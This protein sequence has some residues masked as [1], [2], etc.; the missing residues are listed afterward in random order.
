MSN[1]CRCWWKERHHVQK[2]LQ[3][4]SYRRRQKHGHV[5]VKPLLTCVQLVPLLVERKTPPSVPAKRF[6]PQTAR[7]N[8]S[9]FVKPVFTYFQLAPLLVERKLRRPKSRQRDSCRRR[10]G[11]NSS[12]RQAVIDLCPACAIVG[13]TKT[14]PQYR[15][16]DSCRRVTLYPL[17][18]DGKSRN[19]CVRQAGVS[20]CP[21]CAVVG[22][23]KTRP[24]PVTAKRLVSETAREVTRVSVKPV[25]TVSSLCRCWWKKIRHLLQFR[26]ID[27]Y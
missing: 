2:S 20:L 5:F 13:R 9:V 1:L 26:Q 14:P 27:S 3:R 10:Q 24:S 22:G 8:T 16:R 6:V 17:D 11:I 25:L 23:K 4:D 18:R 21:V 19:I 7:A 15:Q 12:I